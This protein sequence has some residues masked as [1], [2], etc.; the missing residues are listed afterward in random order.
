MELTE[1]QR[2][3]RGHDF[4]PPKADLAKVPAL[5]ATERTPAEDKIIR[6]H[7]FAGGSDWYVAELDPETGEAFG[8]AKQ[9]A[10]PEGAE[11][12]YVS[13]PE[14][15]QV[16]AHHGLVIAERDLDWEPR[17]FADIEKVTA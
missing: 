1:T 11:W 6:Q 3:R 15:E 8:Y 13:L 9:A 17:R 16:S 4:Y 12:G 2:Q 14:L 10:Y 5:Y 7:Y